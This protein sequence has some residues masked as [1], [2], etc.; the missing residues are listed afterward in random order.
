MHSSVECR[1]PFLNVSCVYAPNWWRAAA[2]GLWW[3]LRG[4][5]ISFHMRFLLGNLCAT[6]RVLMH[7]SRNANAGIVLR[8]PFLRAACYQSCCVSQI[9]V[10]SFLLRR[11]SRGKVFIKMFFYVRLFQIICN[12]LLAVLVF[13]IVLRISLRTCCIILVRVVLLVLVQQ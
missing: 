8:F 11:A 1:F 13:D 10:R 4:I 3:N 6:H 7:C 9:C 5:V 2:C 12:Q